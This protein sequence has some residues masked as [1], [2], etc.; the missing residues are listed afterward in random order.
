MDGKTRYFDITDVDNPVQTYEKKIGKMVNMVSS[1]W[2]GK[3]EY[4]TSSLL[5]NWDKKGDAGEQYFKAYNWDGKE[6]KLQFEIDFLEQ[7]LGMAHQMR[8]GA[9]SLYAQAQPEEAV[10]V[11]KTKLEQ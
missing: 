10:K 2:D 6:L 7:K 5:S 11:A 8:F 3:R 9:Y 4:Y 1:S